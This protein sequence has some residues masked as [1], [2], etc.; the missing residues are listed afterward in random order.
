MSEWSYKNYEEKMEGRIQFGFLVGKSLAGK[1]TIAKYMEE[2]LGYRIIDMK[3]ETEKLKEA[4]GTEDAPFEGEIPVEEVEQAI[5]DM[6][7]AS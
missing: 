6:I 1:T 4:K 7:K 5:L 3:A 2:A